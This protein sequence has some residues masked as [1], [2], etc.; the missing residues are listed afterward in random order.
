VVPYGVNAELWSDGAIKSR[1][2]ALPPTAT[3]TV[4]DDGS[5]VFPTGTVLLKT[6]TFEFIAGDPGSRRPVET[7]VMVKRE[8]GWQ[9]HSYQWDADGRDAT[10]L[11]DDAEQTLVIAEQDGTIEL[12]YAWPSRGTCKVCHGFGESRAL[13]PAIAQLNGDHDYG[14]GTANQLTILSG[15]GMFAAPLPGPPATLPRIPARDEQEASLELRARGYLHTNC[16]HCHRPDGWT[17]PDLTMDLRWSTPLVDT[18][19]C[20]VPTQY[21]NPWTT[22]ELRVAAGDPESSVIWQRI[23]QR[24][25]GQMPLLGTNRVD[26]GATVVRDWIAQLS[27]CP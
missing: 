22:G 10:L 24:G 19:I 4:A 21:D 11:L 12:D 9:F 15:L 14:D 17:P 20:D 13:G 25:P 1:F 3:I 27:A 2:I 16:G 8:H 7:R 6:F 18:R 26:P 5:F 23:G